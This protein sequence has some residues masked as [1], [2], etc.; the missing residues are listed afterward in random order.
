MGE[1]CYDKHKSFYA[2]SVKE[3]HVD[4]VGTLTSQTLTDFL[5]FYQKSEHQAELLSLL[6]GDINNKC[7]DLSYIC[8]T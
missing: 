3:F 8:Q 6:Q 1:F 4:K 5:P 2:N 7:S